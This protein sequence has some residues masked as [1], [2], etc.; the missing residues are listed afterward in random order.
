MNYILLV[1]RLILQKKKDYYI[2]NSVNKNTWKLIFLLYKYFLS[3]TYWPIECKILTIWLY[4]KHSSPV[5]EPSP[6]A[7]AFLF[8]VGIPDRGTHFFSSPLTVG[9]LVKDLKGLISI[10]GTHK[11]RDSHL[12]VLGSSPIGKVI[13]RHLLILSAF[14]SWLWAKT[15]PGSLCFI[16]SLGCTHLCFRWAWQD[17]DE[18]ISGQ[19]SSSFGWGQRSLFS[20]P[21]SP[22]PEDLMLWGGGI[23][24]ANR[25]WI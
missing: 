10:S 23:T 4:R 7:A 2:L 13:F 5:L 12:S 1:S 18:P 9:H 21:N 8:S 19:G 6:S 25:E 16:P 3:F 24:S 17:P 20:V 14:F 22:F 11:N 15:V